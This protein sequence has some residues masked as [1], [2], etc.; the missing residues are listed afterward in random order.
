MPLVEIE[1][2]SLHREVRPIIVYARP[3]I[4]FGNER[5]YFTSFVLPFDLLF[6]SFISHEAE[7]A[8][9]LVACSSLL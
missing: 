8:C 6:L 3:T 5:I 2:A 9:F 7:V 4:H 1:H